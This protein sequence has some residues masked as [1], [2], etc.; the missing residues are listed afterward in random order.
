ME[1]FNTNNPTGWTEDEKYDFCKMENK[2][3]KELP[4]AKGRKFG[5]AGV[6]NDPIFLTV[7]EI[8]IDV[9]FF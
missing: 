1:H 5:F 9:V 8:N 2:W 7:E 4:T 6:A 3:L